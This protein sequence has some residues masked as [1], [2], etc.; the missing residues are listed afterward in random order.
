[1]QRQGATSS[2]DRALAG[3][4]PADGGEE[5]R[6]GGRVGG[7]GPEAVGPQKVS[8]RAP[9]GL[10]PEKTA[11]LRWLAEIVPYAVGVR[12][13]RWW[14]AC[15]WGRRGL[16][17]VVESFERLLA[18][19]GPRPDHAL[20]VHR[21]LANDY[22]SEW[23][24]AA[25]ARMPGPDLFRWVTVE[26]WEHV[27]SALVR[28]RGVVLANHHTSLGHLL[29]LVMDRKGHDVHTVGHNFLKLRLMSLDDPRD[30]AI[31]ALR[32]QEDMP[33]MFLAHLENARRVLLAGG[34][35]QIAPDGGAGRGGMWMAVQGRLWRFREGFAELADMTGAVVL[36]VFVTI[37]ARE[38]IT[39]R[40]HPPLATAALP[41]KRPDRIRTLMANY[42]ACF[43]AMWVG[44]PEQFRP[45]MVEKY[46]AAR[47]AAAH[48]EKLPGRGDRPGHM[49]R[50]SSPPA[51]GEA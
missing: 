25:L 21:F 31:T 3:G 47:E 27:E 33:Q 18:L 29:S 46:L 26:G 7:R 22:G 36:P 19:G 9:H 45:F 49:R 39:V 50:A 12:L 38:H 28:G 5:P 15:S 14:T 11:R 42:G 6:S 4:R 17:E 32:R 10:T 37:D 43:E 16:A 23:R 34:V 44:S 51:R 1:M 35:V 24:L 30:P 20:L 8:N 13:I 40:F 41:A 2:A 48:P